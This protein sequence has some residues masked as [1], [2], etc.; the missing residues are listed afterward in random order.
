MTTTRP[1]PLLAAVA[2]VA[3]LLGQ[4]PGAAEARSL[5]GVVSTQLAAF[6]LPVAATPP[7]MLLADDF[8]TAGAI[9]GRLPEHV[10]QPSVWTQAR[11]KWAARNGYLDPPMQPGAIVTFPVATTDVVVEIAATITSAFDFGVVLW[12]DHLATKYVVAHIGGPTNATTHLLT[13]DAVVGNTTTTR[14]TVTLPAAVSPFTLSIS[15]VGSTVTVRRNGVVALVSTF[16]TVDQTPFLGLGYVGVW[17][18]SS[19]NEILD[20]VRA[21]SS[22]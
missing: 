13:L 2:L 8:T 1:T 10:G 20:D 22:T 16:S 5:G 11:G 3:A 9:D 6:T 14:A 21:Y 17:V 4:A 18:S 7:A 15:A 12:S 19:G